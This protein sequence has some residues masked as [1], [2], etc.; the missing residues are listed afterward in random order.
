MEGNITTMN[1]NGDV[2]TF[3]TSGGGGNDDYDGILNVYTV[4]G[5]DSSLIDN[6]HSRAFAKGY[7]MT[8]RDWRD[9]EITAYLNIDSNINDQFSILTR[10]GKHYGSNNCEGFSYR[11]D[12]YYDGTMR[13]CKEQFHERFFYTP[14]QNVTGSILDKWIGMKFCCYNTYHPDIMQQQQQTNQGVILETHLDFN[15]TNNWT[16]VYSYTD[17]GKWG[18]QGIVCNGASDQIGSWGGPVVSLKWSNTNSIQLKWLSVREVNP[19]GI[20]NEGG[21]NY[22]AARGIGG[23]GFT[24]SGG[25]DVN[26]GGFT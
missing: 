13:Q 19:Y 10:G 25:K 5:Y 23:R 18:N 3:P 21:S 12:L 4:S 2:Y 17:Y 15:A 14:T 1:Q 8:P 6:D 7:M 11:T 22:I 26:A 16:K 24:G 20:T 9:V